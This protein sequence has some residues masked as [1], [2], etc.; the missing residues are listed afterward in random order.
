MH[1]NA[2]INFLH[3]KSSTESGWS[4]ES[5]ILN[6]KISMFQGNENSIPMELCSNCKYIVCLTSLTTFQIYLILCT[7]LYCWYTVLKRFKYNNVMSKLMMSL[8]MSCFP[9]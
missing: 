1:D 7:Y 4:L 2:R 9:C 6:N 8:P 5:L 3:F